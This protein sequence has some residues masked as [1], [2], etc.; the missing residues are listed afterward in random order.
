MKRAL[1]V[2]GISILFFVTLFGP[3][4]FVHGPF[5]GEVQAQA[6]PIPICQYSAQSGSVTTTTQLIAQ[7]QRNI[8][9]CK[10]IFNVV[11][12]SSPVNFSLIAGTGPTCAGG[13]SQVTQVYT[14][15]ASST[16]TYDQSVDSSIG[17]YAGNNVGV[18]LSLSGTP[19]GASA[20]IFYGLY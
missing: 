4:F 12:S 11:Q 14:G 16:Q 6:P 13:A 10:V 18:C 3:A 7:N 17:W 1:V 9:V 19:T 20:Q 2:L 15:V 8:R 5:T